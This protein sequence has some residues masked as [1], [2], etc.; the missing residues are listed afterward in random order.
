MKKVLF[1]LS[2]LAATQLMAQDN[3]KALSKVAKSNEEIQN[4]KKAVQVKTWLSRA[5]LFVN[6]WSEPIRN[7]MLNMS[8]RDVRLALA[9][10]KVKETLQEDIEGTLYEVDVY[11]N[12]KLYYD[13]NGVLSFWVAA[14]PVEGPLFSALTAY[15]EAIKLD[16]KGSSIKK[17]RAGLE[18]LQFKFQTDAFAAYNLHNYP[19][20]LLNFEHSL[21]CSGSSALGKTDT[22]TIY[23]TGLIARMA[24]E[25][26]KAVEYMEKAINLGYVQDG[27]LYAS[28][29]EVLQVTGD[30][31]TSIQILT[32]G[33]AKYPTNQSIIIGLINTF[34]QRG[35]DPKKV[36][37]YIEQAQQNDPENSS[38]YYAEGVVYEQMNDLD[39]A[40]LSY[41]KSLEKDEANFFS[42]YSLG[43]LYFN[44]AVQIQNVAAMEPDDKKYTEMIKDVDAQFDLSLP[45]LE[46]AYAL[47]ESEV[48]V[49]E[50]LK[51]L[52]FRLREKSPEMQE[53]Y[54][55]FNS[56]LQEM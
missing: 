49:L 16:G 33:M 50:S 19:E 35:E 54:E 2:F 7:V 55:F 5:E 22:I 17:I 14:Y 30:T 40:V 41:K 6:I 9:T 27:D 37:P 45:Y 51:S 53:K 15:E 31:A 28:Y 26:A 42:N 25:N 39:N 56:K 10:E 20:A 46:R 23:Y 29:A 8:K 43:A 4:P 18:D 12:K 24:G 13:E 34:L 44:K 48:A 1:I 11:D 47:K 38:L 21:A 32:D 52:Y 36:L 3:A